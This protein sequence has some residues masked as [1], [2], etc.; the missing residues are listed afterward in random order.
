[1]KRL[2]Y[3]LLFYTYTDG[4]YTV[5]DTLLLEKSYRTVYLKIFHFLLK[6]LYMQ[7]KHEKN[8]E[9]NISFLLWEEVEWG[10]FTWTMYFCIIYFTMHVYFCNQKGNN[11]F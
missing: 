2:F 10:I 8:Q 1:M 11:E 5:Q 7:Y 6:H 9:I 3:K 4:Y